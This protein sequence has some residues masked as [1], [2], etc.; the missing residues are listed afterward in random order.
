MTRPAAW[1]S[2]WAHDRSA[3][4]DSAELPGLDLGRLQAYLDAHHPT[5]RS[6]DSDGPCAPSV[7]EGGKSNLTYVVSDGVTEFVV[8]RPPLGHVLATAHDMA[9]EFRVH[10]RARPDVGAGAARRTRC[11][12]TPTSSGR[13]SIVME[14]VTGTVYRRQRA[15]RRA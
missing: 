1:S 7:I 3:V 11:A 15:D 5:R 14:F 10:V 6:A 4:D 13:R 12:T 9:R 2:R 8:R